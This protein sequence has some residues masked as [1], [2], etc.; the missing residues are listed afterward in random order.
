[1]TNMTAEERTNAAIKYAI[2]NYRTKKERSAFLN[3]VKY[4]IDVSIE[5]FMPVK[6]E[7]KD[8]KDK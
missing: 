7:L 5:E 1:M 6:N 8:E 3:G 2:L 4:G